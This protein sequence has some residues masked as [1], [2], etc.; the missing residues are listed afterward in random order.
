[1][2]TFNHKY[3]TAQLRHPLQAVMLI[4][5][6][7]L[8]MPSVS[9]AYLGLCCAHCGGNMPLNILGGGIPETHEFRFKLSQML[10]G[11]AGPCG[12]ARPIWIQDSLLGMPLLPGKFMRRSPRPCRCT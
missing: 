9:L 11:Y 6:G 5:F 10:H 3:F 4:L 12:M 2:K 1:M 7:G 8:L